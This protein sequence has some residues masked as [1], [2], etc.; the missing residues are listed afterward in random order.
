MSL[1]CSIP[2]LDGCVEIYNDAVVF[3]KRSDLVSRAEFVVQVLK[4]QIQRNLNSRL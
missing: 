3:K 4:E 1:V 2:E